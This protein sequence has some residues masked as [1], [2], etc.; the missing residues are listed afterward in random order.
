MN[1]KFDGE[2]NVFSWFIPTAGV[3]KPFGSGWGILLALGG[4]SLWPWS[5]FSGEYFWPLTPDKEFG[6]VGYI[7][8]LD[9]DCFTASGI[10]KIFGSPSVIIVKKPHC[11]T[12]E[13]YG[14]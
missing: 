9:H 11:L 12:L 14:Y 1:K 2:K 8:P 5:Y 6:A 13:I 4:E 10:Y 7:C 3:G